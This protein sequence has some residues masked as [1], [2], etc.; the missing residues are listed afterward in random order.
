MQVF[1]PVTGDWLMVIGLSYHDVLLSV[2][3]STL[4][5]LDIVK[6]LH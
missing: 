2:Q 3:L 4:P 1:R 6:L 5:P